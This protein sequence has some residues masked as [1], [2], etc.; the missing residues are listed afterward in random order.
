MSGSKVLDKMSAQIKDQISNNVDLYLNH[1]ANEIKH[2][3]GVIKSVNI[4]E[5]ETGANEQIPTDLMIIATGTK[6]ETSLAKKTGCNLGKYG[7]II[8]N[9]KSETSVDNLYAVGDCTEYIDFVT[10]KS[11]PIGLGSIAVRQSIAAGINAGGGNY[12]LPSGVLQTRTTSV[13]GFEI[14]AVGPTLSCL[15]NE[16]IITGKFN[17]SSLPDYYPGGKPISIK[18]FVEEDSGEIIAAQAVGDKAA[19]R[20]NTFA[21][22][23]LGKLNIDLFKKLETAYAPPIA[24]TLEAITLSC[25]VVSM[26]LNRK[27]R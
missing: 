15:D 24:P 21:S 2:E 23:V 9:E 25:D 19:Q 16:N 17:G 27:K 11:A 8:V 3:K 20:I 22:A 12:S 26:K 4:K 7:H 5:R 10:K 18:V 6:P 13:F 1:F 14:A